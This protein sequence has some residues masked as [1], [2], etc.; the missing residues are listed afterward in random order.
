MEQFPFTNHH[1]SLLSSP[2]ANN[3]QSSPVIRA[4]KFSNGA[5]VPAI[6]YDIL[7]G[8]TVQEFLKLQYESGTF[9]IANILRTGTTRYLGWEYNFRPFLKRYVVS[10]GHAGWF[11]RYAPNKTMLR[12]AMRGTGKI[13]EIHEIPHLK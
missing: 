9:H 3:D 12:M 13:H 7:G 1:L 11:T 8:M 10:V 5:N 2:M 6:A 4:E